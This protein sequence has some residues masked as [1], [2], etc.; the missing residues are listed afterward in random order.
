MG[1][2]GSPSWAHA[3]QTSKHMQRPVLRP[4]PERL[5]RGP[6]TVSRR[7]PASWR[8]SSGAGGP[9]C[10]APVPAGTGA[11]F[12]SRTMAS[13]AAFRA[14]SRCSLLPTTLGGM[15]RYGLP[16]RPPSK[17]PRANLPAA[18]A[19]WSVRWRHADRAEAVR[20]LK[21]QAGREVSAPAPHLA[22]SRRRT[23]AS[24]SDSL[25]R[26]ASRLSLHQAGSKGD[27][28]RTIRLQCTPMRQIATAAIAAKIPPTYT[29]TFPPPTPTRPLA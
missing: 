10:A 21:S 26:P 12:L 16:S 23:A 7:R 3:P 9:T 18:C 14:R 6:S 17:W 24:M 27:R 22:S 28:C 15:R 4:S 2:M 19:A 29:S 11:S 8:G 25:T 20:Q 13:A 1:G 5:A